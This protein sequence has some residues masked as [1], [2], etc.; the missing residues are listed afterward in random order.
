[1]RYSIDT[2]ALIAAYREH[3]SPDV[4]PDVWDFMGQLA[5][6]EVLGASEVVLQEL[7][8]RDDEL[9]KWARQN[10]QMFRATDD[11]IQYEVEAILS[12]HGALIDEESD[13]EQADPFVIALAR[14]EGC[15]VVTT[16]KGTGNPAKPRI[17]DVS[18]DL[19]LQCTTP[20]G[21]FRA[22]GK[23]FRA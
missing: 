23:V 19:G 5:E 16:E 3:Y 14:I 8:Q 4:F 22:E 2:S 7:Q 11:T 20:L 13:R 12:T 9:L 15:A 6:D 17:P 10:R 21:M 18:R 1:M